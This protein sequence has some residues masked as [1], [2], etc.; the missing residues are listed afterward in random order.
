MRKLAQ[1]DI[2]KWKSSVNLDFPPPGIH[3]VA[4]KKLALTHLPLNKMAAISQTTFL[5]AFSLLKMCE[6]RFKFK[7][8]LKFVSKGPI[9]YIPAL[10]QIM[11][12]RRSA[13]SHCQWRLVYW[14]IF[15][16]L[17]PSELMENH[18]RLPLRQVKSLL[19]RQINASPA[20]YWSWPLR[21][22]SKTLNI[23][24]MH[25]RNSYGMQFID[26]LKIYNLGIFSSLISF[27]I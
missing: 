21:N 1:F 12:W 9:N 26:N 20:V 14:L 3:C 13:T 7:I 2:H 24:E 17:I 5:N 10:V 22:L 27:A 23:T 15:G 16:S 8:S 25:R 11:A 4:C 18:R 19:S 6:F